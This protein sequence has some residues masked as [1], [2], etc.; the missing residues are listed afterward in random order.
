MCVCVCVWCRMQQ[1]PPKKKPNKQNKT[2]W[3]RICE[4]QI[5]SLEREKSDTMGFMKWFFFLSALLVFILWRNHHNTYAYLCGSCISYHISMYVVFYTL[6]HHI[7]EL[8]QNEMTQHTARNTFSST[9]RQQF[10]TCVLMH[11]NF[12]HFRTCHAVQQSCMPFHNNF[13][14]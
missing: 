5:H 4:Y 11:A 12:V 13:N 7:Y 14:C 1:P 8:Y 3:N 9:N 10:H 2:R 6:K